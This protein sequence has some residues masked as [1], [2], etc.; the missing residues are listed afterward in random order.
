[1]ISPR[2]W[3]VHRGLPG[4]SAIIYAADNRVVGII[5]NVDDAE[6]IVLLVKD[7]EEK[8]KNE[9]SESIHSSGMQKPG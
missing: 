5:P 1:M 6:F 8:K 3:R 4:S 2:P 9:Q 7:Y